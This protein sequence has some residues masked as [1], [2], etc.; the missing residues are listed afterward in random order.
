MHHYG[1]IIGN[2]VI[3]SLFDDLLAKFIAGLYAAYNH[4]GIVLLL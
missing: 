4:Y 3:A 2:D 1:A